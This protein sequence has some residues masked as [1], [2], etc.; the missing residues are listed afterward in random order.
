[1]SLSSDILHEVS[2][3]H[4]VGIGGSGM[5]PLVEI[6]HTL[7][8]TITGSD[9]NESDNIKRISQLERVSVTIG[10]RAE[11]VQGA[12]MLVYTSAVSQENPELV[13]A[14]AA[15][16]PLIERAK[17][18]GMIS[19]RFPQTVAVAGTHGKTTVTSMISQI[20]LQADKDPTLFIGGRLPLIQANG[21]AGGSD[22]MVCEAC[23]FQNHYLEME[24][25]ISLILNVDADHLEFF[26]DLDGVIRSFAT[27]ASQTTGTIVYNA[28]DPNTCKAIAG[29][30]EEKRLSYGLTDAAKWHA[31]NVKYD[32]AY[33]EYDLFCGERMVTHVRLG[34]PGEHNIGNSV[35]AA[36][37]ATL[38][39]ASPAEIANGLLHFRGAGRRFEIL[40]EFA[41]VTV[42]DD[43]AHHP[44]EI[45]AT[46]STAKQMPFG[47]VWAVFQPFTFSRTARHLDAF[48]EALSLADTAVVS[49]I[50]GS[51]EVNSWNVYANQI[52]EKMENGIHIPDFDG[53]TE[54]V[55]E[56]VQ[57]G[58]LVVSMG[59]G[60]VYKCARMIV[61][62][63]KNK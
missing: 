57:P 63:L 48:A 51:R 14:K 2:H 46:L 16:I 45:R 49:D 55:V 34:V 28:D 25:A 1:M 27:F 58:D 18:L 20:L 3:I 62:K 44:T 24:P 38:C 8:Y 11:N 19:K 33:G 52:T 15:G 6:L 22:T 30:P 13:A 61:E 43:Y 5:S 47:H 23:E 56:H 31:V 4:F 40:G 10:H 54:Y 26:G 32:G 36:A 7:G 9:N 50:M 21:R 17:L 60:D 41:G 42:V 53:I 59:G 12:E 35:G 29:V 39:G 37:V